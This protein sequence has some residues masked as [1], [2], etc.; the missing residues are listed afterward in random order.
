MLLVPGRGAPHAERGDS[1]VTS[2]NNG[3]PRATFRP[4]TTKSKRLPSAGCTGMCVFRNNLSTFLSGTC[5]PASWKTCLHAASQAVCRALSLD[6]TFVVK[7]PC[8]WGSGPSNPTAAI[9]RR[10]RMAIWNST[11][12]INKLS[13]VGATVI[14][15]GAKRPVHENK[16]AFPVE[17]AFRRVLGRA[18]ARI[19]LACS[20]FSAALDAWYCHPCCHSPNSASVGAGVG[21]LKPA[22]RSAQVGLDAHPWASHQVPA[23]SAWRMQRGAC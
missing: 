20:R 4:G 12:L 14:Q 13:L 19:K 21:G 10:R 16:R 15:A 11:L 6:P 17:A 23:Y 7:L 2:T 22:A 9:P 8:P 1:T 3:N 5:P 18:R